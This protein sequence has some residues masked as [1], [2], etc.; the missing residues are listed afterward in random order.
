[1]KKVLALIL[2]VLMIT[3]LVACSGNDTEQQ[4]SVDSNIDIIVDSSE[5]T[6]QFQDIQDVQ[7][8]PESS[9]TQDLPSVDQSSVAQVLL[10]DFKEIAAADP[11]ITAEEMASALMG[12]EAITFEAATMPIEPGLLSG[13]GNAEITGFTEGTMFA[14]MIGT[15]PFVGYIFV[16]DE[17][18]D[19]EQFKVNLQSNADLRWNICVEADEMVVDNV[20][21]MV[22]F[23]M[24]PMS[25]D[26]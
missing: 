22:F 26:A 18:T 12:N 5:P 17:A 20:G 10:S 1:M 21:N 9:D 14:P 6:D 16:V 19:V 3:T 8:T 4:S 2:T 25:L 15:I 23:V 13:F 24:S 7:D 11:N